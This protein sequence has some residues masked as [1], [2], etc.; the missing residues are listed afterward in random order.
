[1]DVQDDVI[2]RL[3]MY[4]RVSIQLTGLDVVLRRYII[5]Y[6][7]QD[8]YMFNQ[9]MHLVPEQTITHTHTHTH[10]HTE[11]ER[12]RKRERE[13]ERE[14]QRAMT[15][16]HSKPAWGRRNTTGRAGAQLFF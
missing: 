6:L 12:E 7:C 3:C 5:Y 4:V 11:R 10:T 14:R 16:S 8:G 15:H 2:I 13:R 9:T 1:M